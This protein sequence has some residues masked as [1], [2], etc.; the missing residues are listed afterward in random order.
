MCFRLRT[1]R[2]SFICYKLLPKVTELRPTIKRKL[3]NWLK[4]FKLNPSKIW[5][6]SLS[7]AGRLGIY[8][9]IKTQNYIT[10]IKQGIMFRIATENISKYFKICFT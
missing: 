10:H 2:Q 7:L 6:S 8:T 9:Q 5:A 1:S 3:D 4:D